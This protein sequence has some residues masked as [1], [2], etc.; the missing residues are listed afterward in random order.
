M[1]LSPFLSI[2]RTRKHTLR[3]LIIPTSGEL[4]LSFNCVSLVCLW[5]K[6]TK[7]VIHFIYFY[8]QYLFRFTHM[9]NF[10]NS[11]SFFLQTIGHF[12]FFSKKKKNALQIF[13]W[14]PTLINEGFCFLLKM[15]SFQKG[16]STMKSIELT[17]FPSSLWKRHLHALAPPLL[18]Q[19]VMLWLLWKPLALVTERG[20]YLCL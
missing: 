8:S 18:W 16:V 20:Q 19:P 13:F 14:W 7:Y 10:Q 17:F 1:L 15:F 3:P 11:F 4:L 6:P 9:F 5:V 2:S 12:L